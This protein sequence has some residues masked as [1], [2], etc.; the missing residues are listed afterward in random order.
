MCDVQINI[1]QTLNNHIHIQHLICIIFQKEF[2]YVL[3]RMLFYYILLCPFFISFFSLI[4]PSM[5][6]LR[7]CAAVFENNTLILRNLYNT[8]SNSVQQSSSSILCLNVSQCCCFCKELC[9]TK[10]CAT[11]CPSL[12]ISPSPNCAAASP[13][14]AACRNISK[15]LSYDCSTPSPL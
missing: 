2:F 6:S 14:C 12:Y 7:P 5:A 9:G 1:V 13:N 4:K 8:I 11:P 3:C 15:A 10:S